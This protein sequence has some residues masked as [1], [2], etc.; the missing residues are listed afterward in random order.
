VRQVSVEQQ[1]SHREPEVMRFSM[2]GRLAVT[3]AEAAQLL[4][5]SPATMYRLLERRLIHAKKVGTKWL[6]P[7]STLEQILTDADNLPL[8]PKG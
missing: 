7:V 5:L 1:G 6:V 3:A 4:G 2:D 8:T